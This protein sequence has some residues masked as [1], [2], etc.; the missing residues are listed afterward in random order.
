MQAMRSLMEP[1][2]PQLG[3]LNTGLVDLQE[4]RGSLQGRFGDAEAALVQMR[5]QVAAGEEA[6][7]ALEL[8]M[9]AQDNENMENR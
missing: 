8:R 5:Y 3:T 6:R 7:A 4:N 1:V 9:E 2:S